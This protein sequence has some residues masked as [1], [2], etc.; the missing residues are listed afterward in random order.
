MK[1]RLTSTRKINRFTSAI[2]LLTL[3]FTH[4]SAVNAL[5]RRWY[6][7]GEL[8]EEACV[9]NQGSCKPGAFFS[10]WSKTG[11]PTPPLFKP[12][13]CLSGQVLSHP[14]GYTT[15][16]N[17][18]ANPPVCYVPVPPTEEKPDFVAAMEP[19]VASEVFRG[20]T[21]DL[22][23]E[24][25]NI[26]DQIDGATSGNLY[27]STDAQF[28]DQDIKLR[29]T[30][31]PTGTL[32]HGEKVTFT[33][34]KFFLPD[35]LPATGHLIW[36]AN[37]SQTLDF[38]EG[39]IGNDEGYEDN[40]D[41]NTAVQGFNTKP[42]APDKPETIE[43]LGCPD[44]GIK[45][46][47]VDLKTGKKMETETDYQ[48]GGVFPLRFTRWYNSRLDQPWNFSY[49][50]HLNIVNDKIGVVLDNGRGYVF[51]VGQNGPV[52]DADVPGRLVQVSG[53]YEY[54]DEQGIKRVYDD[55]GVLQSVTSRSG[56]SH[57]L[58]YTND[59][60]D[61]V[62]D[63]FGNTLQ[64]TSVAGVVERIITPE[65]NEYHY[66]YNAAGYLDKVT[67]PDDTP[68]DLTDNPT[69]EYL[70]ESPNLAS[71]L[72][73]IINEEGVRYSTFAYNPDG[74][75]T[76][77]VLINGDA[78]F[79]NGV[80]RYEFQY[81][82]LDQTVVVTNPLN[83]ISTYH[84]VEIH[85][86]TKIEQ[87][88]GEA[89]TFC[90]AASM[91]RV[92]DDFG[93]LEQIQDN[94]GHITDFTY[95]HSAYT[96]ETI[97]D[98]YFVGLEISRTEAVGTPEERTIATV[99]HATH[100][101]PERIE[102]E[103]K[104]THYLY[105]TDGRLKKLTIEDT[106]TTT[107]PYSTNGNERVWDYTYY[108]TGH[109]SENLLWKIDGPRTDV[110]DIT[111]F[112]YT[113]EGYVKTVTNA[114][115]HVTT[116]NEHADD[117]LPEKITDAN[118]VVTRLTYDERRRLQTQTIESSDGNAVT[119]FKY[120]ANDLLKEIKLPDDVKLTYEYD[121]AMRLDAIENELG[122]RVEFTL[123]E[124]GNRKVV[125]VKD[126]NGSIVRTHKQAFDAL[127][128]LRQNLNAA[129]QAKVT[130]TYDLNDN[131]QTSTDGLNNL[132]TRVFDP[133][134]R[135]SSITDF[136]GTS[137]FDYDDRDNLTQVTDARDNETVYTYSG[138]DDLIQLDSADTG[139]T[140]YEYDDAGNMTEQTRANLDVEI[141]A[142]DELNRLTH[143]SYS[144][145]PA[146]NIVY[147]YDVGL[148]A[149]GRLSS[150][151]DAT[152]STTYS[153]D[154]RGN[155][156]SVSTVIDGISYTTS[157]G[158]DL[159]D[160]VTKITYPSD[161]LVH[162]GR[163]DLGRIESVTTQEDEN[164]P[165]VNV[166]TNISYEP[167]GPVKGWVHGNGIT[168]DSNLDVDSRLDLLVVAGNTTIVSKDHEFDIVDNLKEIDDLATHE[169]LDYDYDELHRLDYAAGDFGTID[170]AYDAVGNR[171]SRVHDDGVTTV[172]ETYDY[173]ID[174]NRIE[175]IVEV[176][177]GLPGDT[178]VFTHDLNGNIET[179]A[180]A[181][182]SFEY[183]YGINNR[184]QSVKKGGVSIAQYSHNALG[185]RVSKSAGSDAL[186]FHYG[187]AGQLLSDTT[188]SGDLVREYI[189]LGNTL[190][191]M[192]TREQS[193]GGGTPQTV[194]I[195]AEDS[196]VQF[197]GNWQAATTFP[198][199]NGSNYYYH[200]GTVQ[201]H[202][203][204]EDGS[205]PPPPDPEPGEGGIGSGVTDNAIV[206]S[207]DGDA[208]A[209]AVN[210]T[211]DDLIQQ[212]TTDASFSVLLDGTN[213]LGGLKNINAIH[214]MG[215]GHYLLSFDSPGDIAGRSY[216]EGDIVD[217]DP[218]NGTATIYLSGESLFG[219][220]RDIDALS[221]TADGR[222]VIS[223]AD[224]GQSTI[225][226]VTFTQ[227]DLVD[228]DPVTDTASIIFDGSQRFGDDW[229]I[230]GVHVD[231]A[232]TIS[233]TIDQSPLLQA[234]VMVGGITT[235]IFTD[236]ATLAGV[237]FNYADVVRYDPVTDSAEVL[238]AG[239]DHLTPDA[240]IDALHLGAPQ[241]TI[242]P[243][244]VNEALVISTS[245]NEALDGLALT[246][247]DLVD[248]LTLGGSAVLRLDG[249]SEVLNAMHLRD[250]GN[251]L[252]SVSA[253]VTLGGL[254]VNTGDIVEYDPGSGLATMFFDGLVNFG[255]S[256]DVD[257]VA[258]L[259]DGRILLSV[260]DSS[261]TLDSLSFNEG[262]LVAYDP[263]TG[264]ASLYLEATQSF[265]IVRDIN[266]VHVR[267]D[268]RV[269]LT[270]S[271][272]TADI[273]GITFS[274]GDVVDYDPVMDFATVIF[275]ETTFADG[276][277][278]IDAL[279]LAEV[280]TIVD[281]DGDGIADASDA[282]P[283][284]A[285]ESSDSD[286]DG[287]GDNSDPYPDDASVTAGVTWPL[288]VEFTGDYEIAV[289]WT[290]DSNRSSQAQYR[291]MTGDEVHTVTVD[292]TQNGGNWVSLGT[293]TLESL[294]VNEVTLTDVGDGYVV[295][296]AVQMTWS[297]GNAAPGSVT[298]L[299]YVHNDHLMTPQIVT[300]S[301]QNVVWQADYL[302][303]GEVEVVVD[304][305]EMP[306]RFPGQY[307]DG[308]T[309]LHYNYFR[310]YDPGLGRYLES[311]P[312]GLGGGIN[313]YNYSTGNPVY[314]YDVYGLAPSDYDA[315]KEILKRYGDKY[316]LIPPP[317]YGELDRYLQ[318]IGVVGLTKNS[319]NR[320]GDSGDVTIT[321]EFLRRCMTDAEALGLLEVFVHENLHYNDSIVDELIL[322]TMQYDQHENSG[323]L[324]GDLI[325]DA[326]YERARGITQKL[327]EPFLKLR[328]QYYKEGEDFF[329]DQGY[330][331]KS[332]SC[333][334]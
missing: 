198:G 320:K 236:T 53:G 245:G 104:T 183:I 215:N 234:V 328:K 166:A 323:F 204:L 50:S 311:D 38:H 181:A 247:G 61:S 210:A 121:D 162:Y 310:D 28:D 331:E 318:A 110:A 170:Y 184:L 309:G 163:D 154:D 7:T 54:L 26:D 92:Y 175:D 334:N 201:T 238:L 114:A 207:L 132:V 295:A 267:D 97:P 73:G 244:P 17:P 279:S 306:I 102:E 22:T 217:Y 32:P 31:I 8:A 286:G 3:T 87:I 223:V 259:A 265:G 131:P 230:N 130:N 269:V 277:A 56:F 313:T 187:L 98:Q 79:P 326:I 220:T 161:R 233:L 164:A 251:Y 271:N 159:A 178:T 327:K 239:A 23:V 1:D 30:D 49:S 41:N 94:K 173:A 292:Q 113:A 255:A 85:G 275:E 111:E 319:W 273:G 29:Q 19:V 82:D 91:S 296:D 205:T 287:V 246:P 179:T 302:P 46:N 203:E 153:Y 281:Y 227:D 133:L 13:P 258:E 72:T 304:A 27:F 39:V 105:E 145:D 222:V 193:S 48:G 158:Y 206:F 272:S 51:T 191:G 266:G 262:D 122:E 257:A 66:R 303:F 211:A 120:Y 177:D 146:Q 125:D 42:I 107:D 144:A 252:M 197:S 126:I 176:V 78:N 299:L 123:D 6:S 76:L 332:C 308:E 285:S 103:G 282:F 14:E 108:A 115:G 64:I 284:D 25:E 142:Y 232:G 305:V 219:E 5:E 182:D 143:I 167:F 128:R 151:T 264:E 136:D 196:G 93:Y 57:T 231:A 180:D 169:Y 74:K 88:D 4:S 224:A 171:E 60:L 129:D 20:T 81:N 77:S 301:S 298:T 84:L 274:N 188:S 263:A 190:I 83:K 2:F 330:L 253:P 44:Q 243:A 192:T 33:D 237:S 58:S 80:N 226:G 96:P 24:I 168:T 10:Y 283:L 69:R 315:A 202:G 112:T 36:V 45:G 294:D 127:S 117:G 106:T 200:E 276:F 225:S 195:D 240:D 214:L 70:Y 118:D 293:F 199:F 11:A 254:P 9:A 67:L 235:L 99:W 189:Y 147:G 322:S 55:S 86:V 18:P 65:Q 172:A 156:K 212:D 268:G 291:V 290:S 16:D 157:Y 63:S 250:N 314:Y 185:Q 194:V 152:G 124:A 174:S 68:G 241:A 278:N 249:A 34:W 160:N 325:H 213:A 100:R 62:S 280:I 270:V 149:K 71:G 218:V 155:V 119:S 289:K 134:D 35:D 165:L 297:S 40:L 95:S 139:K 208:A 321:Q 138:L 209:G 135:L 12:V 221:M 101:L 333:S 137:E 37:P 312:I 260:S 148:N 15:N 317:G 300:N 75:A 140:I 288:D 242:L 52:A 186:H 228:Y 307:F 89:T 47:P 109:A 248:Y 261:A 116:I 150:V 90:E 324:P 329:L 229:D 316:G 59:E 21:I 256:R 43:P 141:R 216:S